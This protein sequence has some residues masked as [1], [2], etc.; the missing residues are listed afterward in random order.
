MKK[1]ML[2]VLIASILVG[3]NRS[4]TPHQAANTGGKTCKDRH[5]I[6]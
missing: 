1:L 2:I 5:R 3:C 6:R 4:F